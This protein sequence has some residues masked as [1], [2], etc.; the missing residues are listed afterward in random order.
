MH[1]CGTTHVP[2]M[3]CVASAPINPCRQLWDQALWVNEAFFSQHGNR[4]ETRVDHRKKTTQLVNC[5]P[6]SAEPHKRPQCKMR[7]PCLLCLAVR[8]CATCVY[9]QRICSQARVDEERQPT[10]ATA[11]QERPHVERA[12]V[13]CLQAPGTRWHSCLFVLTV[14]P[15][16]CLCHHAPSSMPCMAGMESIR[17]QV[18]TLCCPDADVTAGMLRVSC[19]GPPH[20]R[21]QG[22]HVC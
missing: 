21:L 12:C 11:T 16:G 10:A 20:G 2:C 7:L 9:M 6:V 17:I 3:L 19:T 1:S 15:C 18:R 14:L 4:C 22:R 5:S 8:V 13:L